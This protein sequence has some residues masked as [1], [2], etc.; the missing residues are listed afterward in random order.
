MKVLITG[1]SGFLGGA[2]AR[3]LL[4]E[5]HAVRGFARSPMAALAGLGAEVMCGDLADADAVSRAVEGVEFVHHV[6]AKAGV[7]GPMAEY[8]RA[9]VDGTRHVLDA[10]RTHGAAGLVYTSSPSV[11][12]AGADIRGADESLPYATHFETAYP[13]TKAEAE[14]LVLAANSPAFA[15]LALRPHLIWG[16][17]DNQLV[18][19]LM[20]RARAGRLVLPGGG[21]AMIDST[22][23]DS[24]VEAHVLAQGRLK[25]GAP[26]AGKAYFISQGEVMK[27]RA[28]VDAIIGTAGLPPV[29][30]TVPAG[31]ALALGAVLERVWGMVGAAREPPLTRFVVRQMTTDHY[32][33][34]TAARRELGYGPR[35]SIREGIELL[36]AANARA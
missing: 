19:R 24:A 32:F 14:R 16:P 23:I 8:R 5:G 13:E 7:W 1:A 35:T 30:R 20:S 33:D 6:G 31:V 22:F 4:K 18:P 12:H 10:C 36:R 27:L 17:G 3:A 9:N 21:E 28:L 2:L 26:C 34:L 29:T 11:V 15:T 25:P